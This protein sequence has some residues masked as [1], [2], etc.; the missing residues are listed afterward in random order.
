MKLISK[1]LFRT[2]KGAQK[3][4]LIDEACESNIN[5]VVEELVSSENIA[6]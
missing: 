6:S 2:R 5:I 3:K 4:K 1:K